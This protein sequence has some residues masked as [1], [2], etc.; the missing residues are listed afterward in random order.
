MPKTLAG[1]CREFNLDYDIRIEVFYYEEETNP[2]RH[3]ERFLLARVDLTYTCR[4]PF[5]DDEEW[6][7]FFDN[8][9]DL[10]NQMAHVYKYRHG[11]RHEIYFSL[12]DYVA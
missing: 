5:R 4:D 11:R 10:Y 9:M 8:A 12:K 7:E 6:K 3:F 2:Y 1:K